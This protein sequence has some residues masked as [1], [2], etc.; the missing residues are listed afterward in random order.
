MLFG[1]SPKKASKRNERSQLRQHQV[2]KHLKLTVLIWHF[3][4]QKKVFN[5]IHQSRPRDVQFRTQSLRTCVYTTSY[6]DSL[7]GVA[8]SWHPPKTGHVENGLWIPN[9]N[10]N[11][12]FNPKPRHVYFKTNTSKVFLCFG[13]CLEWVDIVVSVFKGFWNVSVLQSIHFERGLIK[14]IRFTKSPL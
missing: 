5:V 3:T 14:S 10:P 12:N 6:P 13:A 7:L 8:P 2:A 9:P 11:P 1:F 4:T